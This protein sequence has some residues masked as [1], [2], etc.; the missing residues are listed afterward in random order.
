M[1]NQQTQNLPQPGNAYSSN[2]SGIAQTQTI[3]STLQNVV[4]AI[5]GFNTALGAF[6]TAIATPSG[7][8]E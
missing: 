8:G 3:V 6:F 7:S 5:N 1:A 2:V 4:I